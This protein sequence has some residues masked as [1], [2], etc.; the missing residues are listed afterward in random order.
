LITYIA[1]DLTRR[2]LGDYPLP[3]LHRDADL[4]EARYHERSERA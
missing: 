2:G 1:C 4:L 3:F